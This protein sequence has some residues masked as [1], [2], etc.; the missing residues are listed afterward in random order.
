MGRKQTLATSYLS[1]RS[2]AMAS[3]I[4]W[5]QSETPGLTYLAAGGVQRL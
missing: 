4:D 3:T 1:G 5:Q 2:S